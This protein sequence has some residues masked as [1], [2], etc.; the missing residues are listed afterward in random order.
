MYMCVCLHFINTDTELG[1]LW[2]TPLSTIVQLYRGG[3][4]FSVIRRKPP[5]C[6]SHWHILSHKIVS[7]NPRHV[8]D[9]NTDCT[10]SC[11]SNWHTITTTSIQIRQSNPWHIYVMIYHYL[12]LR[13]DQSM[14]WILLINWHYIYSKYS[15]LLI[16]PK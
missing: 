14:V 5:T 15:F 16:I 11:K 10:G 7:S 2:L 12:V 1:L 9:S 6:L 3:Q 8:R 4:L 13:E